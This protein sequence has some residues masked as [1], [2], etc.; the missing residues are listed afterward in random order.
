LA[1]GKANIRKYCSLTPI[2]LTPIALRQCHA[3]PRL[4]LASSA[5]VCSATYCYHPPRRWKAVQFD[6]QV[7]LEIMRRFAE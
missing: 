6:E 1:T 4:Y 7:N 5:A 3:S 2:A